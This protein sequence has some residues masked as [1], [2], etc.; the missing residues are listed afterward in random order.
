MYV[1]GVESGLTPRVKSIGVEEEFFVVDRDTG[2]LSDDGWSEDLLSD[3]TVEAACTAELYRAM[4]EV[5]SAPHTNGVKLLA[6]LKHNRRAVQKRLSKRH[7]ALLA[8]GTHPTADWRTSRLENKERYG[9]LLNGYGLSIARALT[10]GMHIHFGFD[11]EGD[12]ISALNNTRAYLPFIAAVSSFSPF[13]CGRYTYLQSY[14]R[15]V[16]D[17]LPRSGIPPIMKSL[18]QYM[19]F[20]RA[21]EDS[22]LLSDST[23]VWWDARI[24]TK[25]DTLEIRIAD[26]IPDV[27]SAQAVVVFAYICVELSFTRHCLY[28]PD[29]L[30]QENRWSATKFGVDSTMLLDFNLP[31]QSMSKCIT[32]ILKTSQAEYV[33]QASGWRLDDLRLALLLNNADVSL[34]LGPNLT[35]DRFLGY[36]L[37]V[38]NESLVC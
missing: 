24:N 32:E 8:C 9:A 31:K 27:R 36:A 38:G 6:E 21:I 29:A 23:T 12:L 37:R 3:S 16:Y 13:W 7:R 15:A 2:S 4:L 22:R 20:C 11:D 17:A 35:A 26:T 5:R 1:M 19:Q 18:E 28:I 25:H 33:A 34:D 10:C 30:I 14:R